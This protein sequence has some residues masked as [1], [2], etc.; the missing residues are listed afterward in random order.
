[1]PPGRRLSFP[2]ELVAG[3]SLSLSGRFQLQGEQAFRGLR[4]WADWVAGAGG[5]SLG[6]EGPRRP[7]RLHC[8]D[9]ESR[10]AR[11]EETVRHLLTHDRVDFLVGPYSSGLTEAVAPL[12]EA[13]GKV[14]WNH[15]GASDA[16]F[17]PGGRRLVSM[18]SPASDYL[19][20]LPAWVRRHDPEARRLSILCA[21]RGDFAGH[22]AEG[23]A[24]GARAAGFDAIRRTP[25]AS[26]LR[27]VDSLLAET[28]AFGP[29]LLVGVGSFRD[30]IEL[31]RHRGR[32]PPTTRLA[33]VAAGLD[34]FHAEL[35]QL[36]EGVIGPSQ[37]EPGL[38]PTPRSGPDAAWFC[39]AFEATFGRRPDYPAA[40]AFALGVILVECVRRAGSLD[41]AA[42]LRAAHALETTTFYGGFRLDPATGRQVG[43]RVH[44][45]QWR[46]GRKVRLSG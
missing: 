10:A 9:D 28:A 15:G 2:R 39:A 19:R 7:L 46:A 37:W 29:D 8:L 5:L 23:A 21:E 12:V 20:A 22:V 44:L 25:F 33:V 34:A 3:V 14:L 42:L 43:H 32:L 45:I 13:R 16:I 31:V 24:D 40:Q 17:Q 36:A 6:P 38:E 18:P 11:A 26:P 30:D 41:D 4:L 1:M 35:G 27:D